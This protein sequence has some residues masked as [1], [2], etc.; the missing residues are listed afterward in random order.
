[1]RTEKELN[2]AWDAL[3]KAGWRYD[4]CDFWEDPVT[5]VKYPTGNAFEILITDRKAAVKRQKKSRQ[6][7]KLL[8]C[9]DWEGIRNELR[10]QLKPFGLT[11]KTK[12]NYKQWGDLLQWT[13][14]KVVEPKASVDDDR[15]P[16]YYCWHK[17]LMGLVHIALDAVA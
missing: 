14:E 11:V 10:R 1:M 5:G 6:S 17:N 16:A 3:K 9:S 4:G 15:D 2:D 7:P 12:G 13:V 8:L